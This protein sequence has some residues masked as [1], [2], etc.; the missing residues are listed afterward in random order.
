MELQLY[1]CILIPLLGGS[2]RISECIMCM[3]VSTC[4]NVCTC[5]CVCM[6]MCVYMYMCLYVCVHVCVMCVCVRV[7]VCVN[8]YMYFVCV[9]T[10]MQLGAVVVVL[11]SQ[12]KGCGFKSGQSLAVVTLSKSL[13]PHCSSVPSGEIGTCLRLGWQK[14]Q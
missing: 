11:G 2:Y 10:W 9:C 4:M 1:T 6:C 14:G 8:V 5:M 7:R 12:S 3:C 13:Y